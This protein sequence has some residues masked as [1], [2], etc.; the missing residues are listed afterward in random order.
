MHLTADAKNQP[1]CSICSKISPSML[2]TNSGTSVNIPKGISF[3]HIMN[4]L[5]QKG[6]IRDKFSF[7]FEIARTRS[8]NKLKAGEYLLHPN[9]PLNQIIHTLV[10]GNV[11]FHKIVVPEGLTVFQIIQLLQNNP[12]LTGSISSLPPEGSLLPGTYFFAQNQSRENMIQMMKTQM[13]NLLR[14]IPQFPANL[15][16]DQFLTLASIVEKETNILTEKPRI[17]GVFLRRMRFNMRLQA[18]PTVIYALTQGQSFNRKLKK[19]DLKIDSTYN[20]YKYHNLPPTPICCPSKETIEATACAQDTGALYFV[21][22]PSTKTHIFST[23][24][25]MHNY[26]IFTQKSTYHNMQ[27]TNKY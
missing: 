7:L 25:K 9:M 14:S 6:I 16:K 1:F 18:D 13:N 20:T 19:Q 22:N 11:I 24:L 23:N 26:H 27:K 15:S 3:I 2:N 21:A 8:W 10:T 17:A 12:C 5:Y 4:I